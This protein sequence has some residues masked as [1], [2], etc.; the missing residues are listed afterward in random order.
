MFKRSMALAVCLF[1]GPLVAQDRLPPEGVIDMTGTCGY[2]D[3][4]AMVLNVARTPP[5][6][7]KPQLTP[8]R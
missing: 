3:F 2:Y 6:A 7:D 1:A 4:L 5:E 8:L